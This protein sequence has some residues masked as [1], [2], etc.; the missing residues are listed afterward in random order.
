MQYVIDDDEV[1]HL[2]Y[3]F[4]H[5]VTEKILGKAVEIRA[6]DKHLQKVEVHIDG[7]YFVTV[8]IVHGIEKVFW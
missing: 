7:T 3:C 8:G 6:L 5:N 2:I 1:A 4:Q